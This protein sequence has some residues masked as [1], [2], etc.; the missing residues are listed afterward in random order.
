ME[1][2][3][4]KIALSFLISIIILFLLTIYSAK[5]GSVQLT[6]DELVKGLFVEFDEK[7]AIVYDLRFPRIAIAIVAGFALAI[8]GVLLQAVMKNPLTDPGIIGI[9][10]AS[11]LLSV[12]T[13]LLFPSLYYIT[14][15]ISVIGGVLA[16]IL[17]YFL[18]WDKG[19]NPIRLILVGVA[20]NMIFLGIL[21]IINPLS[22]GNL[23]NVQAIVQGNISQ[24]TWADVKIMIFY[25]LPAIII[26]LFTFKICNL[27]LLE[28]KRAKALG[29]NV[30][31]DRF[32]VALIAIALASITTSVSGVIGFLGLIVPHIAR[33]I[34]GGNHKALIPFS[35]ILGAIMLLLS[36]TIGRTIVYPLEISPAVIMTIIGGPFFILLLKMGGRYG[37]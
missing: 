24:K 2:K 12:L 9:S 26:S 16:Y 36:D 3:K 7:V 1:S 19:T 37:N 31:R 8:S 4:I 18:A 28:D 6:Y 22:S 15:F 35:G 30:D 17:I 10:S 20:L 13:L 33:I 11:S 14:P 25:A 27:L 5:T 34:I 32:I 21:E 23:T 29:V